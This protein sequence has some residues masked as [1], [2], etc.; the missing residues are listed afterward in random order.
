MLTATALLWVSPGHGGDKVFGSNT[1]AVRGSKG[2]NITLFPDTAETPPDSR[3]PLP[4]PTTGEAEGVTQGSRKGKAEP[5]PGSSLSLGF[6]QRGR[7]SSVRSNS[8]LGGDKAAIRNGDLSAPGGPLEQ[9]HGDGRNVLQA[10]PSVDF[11]PIKA[12]PFPG[13][14]LPG[15][16]DP[17]N[18]EA[19][20][21]KKMPP[22][23]EV[24]GKPASSSGDGGE[25]P[26]A[27][28]RPRPGKMDSVVPSLG[29]PDPKNS[30][31]GDK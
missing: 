17:A 27:A 13:E 5:E 19:P 18:A 9:S 28:G 10:D 20:L 15:G 11:P 30:E 24:S 3:L 21:M 8:L 7:N 14:Y 12:E 23:P 1:P 2:G 25:E 26:A 22:G 16:E 6:I 4:Y 31:G 29:I